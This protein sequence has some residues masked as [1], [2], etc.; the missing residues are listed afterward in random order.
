MKQSILAAAA[1]ALV[2]GASAA[3]GRAASTLMKLGP[4]NALEASV[5]ALVRAI[6][7]SPPITKLGPFRLGERIVRGLSLELGLRQASRKAAQRLALEGTLVTT[8][9]ALHDGVA[10]VAYELSDLHARLQENATLRSGPADATLESAERELGRAASTRFFVVQRAN[11]AVTS[12][13]FP[14]DIN[15][16][17]A[18]VLMTLATS[19]QLVRGTPGE[20]AW[21]LSERDPNGEYMAAY[22]EEPTGRIHK[23]KA[24]YVSAHRAPGSVPALGS[25]GAAA[26]P[27]AIRVAR[28]SYDFRVDAEGRVLDLKSDEALTLTL[29]GLS[30]ELGVRLELSGARI[31]AQRADVA[32]LVRARRAMELR[33]PIEMGIDARA[34]QL[35]RDRQ[36]L[37][38]ATFDDLLRKLD[39]A[40]AKPS[41][42]SKQDAAALD[43]SFQALFRLNPEA[44]ARAPAIV[45]TAAPERGKAIVDAL[46]LAGSD[47]AQLALAEVATDTAAPLVPRE[48]A[49]QYVAQQEQPKSAAIAG[50]RKLLDD[51]NLELRQMARFSY[52]ACARR[53]PAEAHAIATELVARLERA[54][55]DGDREELIMALGNAGAA[56]AFPALERYSRQGAL[57]LRARAL[58][59]LR[60]VQEPK[61]DALLS[62]VL[63]SSDPEPLRLAAIAA[64][65]SREVGP[66]TATLAQMA[67][68]EGSDNVRTAVIDLLGSKLPAFPALRPVLEAVKRGDKLTKNRELAARYLADARGA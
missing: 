23:Q 66:F 17:I 28:S 4:R 45:R 50:L 16:A 47:A 55:N 2:T 62:N 46:S 48:Y 9:A 26:Q 35:R 10:E 67:R 59:A 33:A 58:E 6:E 41:G 53:A 14:R 39:A 24:A 54:P 7:G 11:G 1:L 27:P 65:R 22:R 42:A 63:T 36:L 34:D 15:P 12:L 29:M 5:T 61:A 44:A 51:P 31:A 25:S 20:P 21:V 13:A 3:G 37:N 60:F 38:G 68:K 49:V 8:V 56:A 57:R 64:L 30:F 19:T 52:G 40:A 18:N 43:R 32:E